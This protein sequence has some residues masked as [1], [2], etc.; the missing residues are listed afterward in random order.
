MAT[1]IQFDI[2]KKSGLVIAKC[3]EIIEL[4]KQYNK[5]FDGGHSGTK[6]DYLIAGLQKEAQELKE[7]VD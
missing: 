2:N 7:L 1:G 5:E 3:V 6:M 4:V